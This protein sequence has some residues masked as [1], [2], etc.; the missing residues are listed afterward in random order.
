MQLTS[1]YLAFLIGSL[2]ATQ[3][4]ASWAPDAHQHG[5][6]GGP[7]ADHARA[8][9][10][11]P[12]GLLST[13]TV[14]D[15]MTGSATYECPGELPGKRELKNWL[16]IAVP[17]LLVGE[18][19][20]VYRGA[21]PTSFAQLRARDLV[22]VPGDA[23]SSLKYRMESEN[24]KNQAHNDECEERRAA[25][26]EKIQVE[27]AKNIGLLMAPSSRRSRSSSPRTSAC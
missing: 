20:R 19:E 5:S 17:H 4:G 6:G 10:R 23:D 7:D 3:Q 9:T 1:L 27:L 2:E 14:P 11:R 13:M 8:R 25:E 12:Q 15:S 24:R 21:D 22:I 26:L 18:A 16:D